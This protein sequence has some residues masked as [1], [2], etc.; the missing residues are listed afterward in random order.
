MWYVETTFFHMYFSQCL[1]YAGSFI[2]C[3]QN[4]LMR[5]DIVAV[6]ALIISF[7]TILFS[8][9]RFIRNSPRLEIIALFRDSTSQFG[10][11]IDGLEFSYKGKVHAELSVIEFIVANKS[12]RS[13]EVEDTSH[14][15]PIEIFID[16]PEIIHDFHVVKHVGDSKV[17]LARI[18]EST[19]RLEISSMDKGSSLRIK[20]LCSG[21]DTRVKSRGRLLK[22]SRSIS[23]IRDLR[24]INISDLI[25]DLLHTARILFFVSLSVGLLTSAAV[26]Y[27]EFEDTP[28]EAEIL[29]PENFLDLRDQFKTI[30]SL[31]ES[32]TTNEMVLIHKSKIGD[33]DSFNIEP[34]ASHWTMTW[35][36]GGDKNAM[37]LADSL[38]NLG[39][40][41]GFATPSEEDYYLKNGY[42]KMESFD[43]EPY[44]I[45]VKEHNLDYYISMI[46][47]SL[48]YFAIITIGMV[49]LITILNGRSI[50]RALKYKSFLTESEVDKIKHEYKGVFISGVLARML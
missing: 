37:A 14:D 12:F 34:I 46:Q 35:W 6:G 42:K 24:G 2:F 41:V 47:F 15:S 25:T 4:Y 8:Y 26:I 31:M 20:L 50:Y 19:I 45:M 29:A 17:D 9:Y 40:S 38:T 1:L 30:D 10:K 48:L 7:L 16:S 18:D 43:Y 44:K 49:L 23:K 36:A 11:F 27:I 39:Y 33:V 28:E 13:I 5:I 3:D 32:S 22:A 21:K